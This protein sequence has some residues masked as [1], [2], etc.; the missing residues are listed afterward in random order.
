MY[1]ICMFMQNST[2][3][4]TGSKPSASTT[5]TKIGAVSSRMPIQSMKQ[6]RMIQMIWI[7]ITTPS[8]PT[9]SPVMNVLDQLGAA[10]ERVDADQRRRAEEQPVQH[11][12]HLGRV[13]GG[14][15][16]ACAQLNFPFHHIAM[17]APST[18]TPAASVGVAQP[19]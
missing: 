10:G 9:G 18:P 5:G 12:R 13:L 11:D 3:I 2:P 14:A 7:R 16:A 4:H 6:P 17:T 1:E 15:C 8:G 19:R